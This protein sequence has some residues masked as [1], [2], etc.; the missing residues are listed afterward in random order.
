MGL[1]ALFLS[2]CEFGHLFLLVSSNFF[3][4]DVYNDTGTPLLCRSYSW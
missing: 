4:N 2:I 3:E 1:P